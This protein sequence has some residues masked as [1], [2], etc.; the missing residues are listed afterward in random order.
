MHFGTTAK[1]F[2]I[3]AALLSCSFAML[4]AE[5]LTL[6]EAVER[7]RDGNLSIQEGDISVKAAKRASS[8][9][10]N[11]VSPTIRASGNLSK[12]L[13]ES[14]TAS[15]YGR[16]SDA[17]SISLGASINIGLSP[18]IATSIKGAR[19][20]YEKQLIDYDS[21][22]RTIELNVRRA[23]YQ[24]L[25]E[26]EYIALQERNAE[27]AK[28]QYDTNKAKYE[29]GVLPRLDVLNSQIS[30]QNAQLAL[31]NA[32]TTLSNDMATFKNLLGMSQSTPLE[33]SGS[34][35]RYAELSDVSVGGVDAKPNTIASLEKQVEIARNSLMATRLSAWAPTLSAGY[36]YS[37]STT[38]DDSTDWSKGGTLSIGVNIPIDGFLPWSSG[39]QS[40]ARQKDSLALAEMQLE[41]ARNTQRI[42]VDNGLSQVKSLVSAIGLRKQGLEVAEESYRLTLEAYNN[43]TKDIIVLQNARNGLFEAGVNLKN[44]AYNLAV[45][46]LNLENALGVPFGSLSGIDE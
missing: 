20:S 45:A 27:M 42:N 35:D 44:Q 15:A 23:F 16:S 28:T 34:L 29:R 12:A 33:L 21:T 19:L 11:S 41:D 2:L 14:D 38:T 18:S 5:S 39:A 13:P 22:V 43:G 24:I 31:D 37:L 46:L 30:W 3:S 6:R 9:S 32:R 25:Y 26:Q 10:W 4:Q 40:I 8:Y 7:A 36:S 1:A 17:A